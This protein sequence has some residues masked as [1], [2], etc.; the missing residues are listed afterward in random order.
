MSGGAPGTWARGRAPIRVEQTMSIVS[1]GSGAALT[2]QAP[3]ESPLRRLELLPTEDTP[4][5]H[6][7]VGLVWT[8]IGGGSATPHHHGTAETGVYVLAGTVGFHRGGEPP[9]HLEAGPGQFVFIAPQ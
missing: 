7:G 2:E 6:L 8:A 1:L 9:D 5:Q 3:G 4:T